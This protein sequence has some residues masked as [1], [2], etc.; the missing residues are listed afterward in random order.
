MFLRVSVHI[1]YFFSIL[2]FSLLSFKFDVIFKI[3]QIYNGF[4][5]IR[6]QRNVVVN[7]KITAN[8]W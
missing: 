2:M 6:I 5:S 8:I 1:F 4:L 3:A 7:W